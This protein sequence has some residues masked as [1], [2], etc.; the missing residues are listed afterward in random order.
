MHH[1]HHHERGHG[2]IHF[3]GP[4]PNRQD[5]LERLENYRRDLEQELADVSDVIEHLRDKEAATAQNQE[6]T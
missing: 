6:Q 1:R 4:F 5:L 2:R 3:R